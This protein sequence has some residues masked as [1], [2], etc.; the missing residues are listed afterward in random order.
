MDRLASMNVFVKTAELGSFVAVAKALRMSPQ[1]VA[2]H[3][4]WLEARLGATL[5]N[6]TTRRQSLTAIGHSYLERCRIVVAE[7]E[8]ADAS[9]MDMR[10]KPAGLLRV[11]A[12]VTFGSYALAPFVARYL[13]DYPETEV[14]LIL[15][16]RY[17][18]LIEDGY[19]VV[20][21]I[22]ELSGSSIIAHPLQPYRLLVCASPDYIARNG[23]PEKPADLSRHTCLIYGTWSPSMP[24]RW[25]FERNG[26][27]EEVRPIG[28][29]QSND[30]KALLYAALDGQGI[31]LGPADVLEREIR[32][33]RL[34]R[35]LQDYENPARPM[36]LLVP[37]GRRVSTKVRYFVNAVL[38]SFGAERAMNHGHETP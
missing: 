23:S 22:G 3:V 9:V 10:V 20:I 15:S 2:K 30:W 14:E 8:A 27:A 26:K 13:R 36:H 28:R 25:T 31:I 29:F 5:I 17:V 35:I 7:A 32:E 16:D 21:R 38:D 19:E 37:P 11:N 34:V 12:P 1:M 4:A 6:R 33:G 18:D 24:C